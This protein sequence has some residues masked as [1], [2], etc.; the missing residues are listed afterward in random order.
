VVVAVGDDL[1]GWPGHDKNNIEAADRRQL[2]S[3]DPFS[4]LTP[5]PFPFSAPVMSPLSFCP[6]SVLRPN[7]QIPRHAVEQNTTCHESKC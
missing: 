5:F 6:L 4:A 2:I 1:A 3:S 7:Y